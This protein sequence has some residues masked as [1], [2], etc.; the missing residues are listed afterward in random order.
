[1]KSNYFEK[2]IKYINGVYKMDTELKNLTDDRKNPIYQTDQVISLVLFGFLLRIKSFNELKALIKN[3]EFNVLYPKNTVFPGVDTVRSTLKGLSL[4]RLRAVNNSL[5]LKTFR[6]KVFTDGTI[7]GY[8]VA[9]IDGTKFFGSNKKKCDTCLRSGSHSYHSGVVMSLIGEG[10]RLVMDFEM[11]NPKLDESRK[12][13]GEL[14]ASKR[15]VS[16]LKKHMKNKIDVIVYDAL[17][18]NSVWI[19]Q[20]I[21]DDF[22][23]IV[24]VKKNNNKSLKEAKKRLSKT[25]PVCVWYLERKK[26]V[27]VY[28][29]TFVMGHVKEPLR[30]VKFVTKNID[31]SR[32]QIIIITT[33][34]KASLIT[35]YKMI[36]A[37]W[38]IENTIFNN[39]KNEY[40]LNHCF[41]HGENSV[42]AV[43]GLIFLAHNLTQ[44]FQKRRIKSH[45]KIQ[46]ELV[47]L[48]WKGLYTLKYKNVNRFDT[49]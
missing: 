46:R 13:E 1:M 37:R 14:T 34:K 28:E 49:S 43:I 33:L 31:D 8:V 6:N 30:M 35:L 48:F 24:R 2:L 44:L 15:L 29:E 11:M 25:E 10:P 45:V 4:S 12:D 26:Q 20:L 39:L 18:C 17:A 16:R 9:A 40:N 32:S 38:H 47:R 42:E 36:K 23:A 5:V 22:H 3:G 27:K 41:V 19:N 7:D 21:D